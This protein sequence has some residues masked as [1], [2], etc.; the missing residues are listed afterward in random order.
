MTRAHR[1]RRRAWWLLGLCA[2]LAAVAGG[3]VAVLATR[4]AA[5]TTEAQSPLLGKPAPD[6]GGAS[7]SGPPVSLASLRGRFVLVNFFASWCAPCRT[8]APELVTLA[9]QHK[10]TGD[11]AIVGVTFNDSAQAALAFLR[12]TGEEWPAIADP[13]GQIALAYGVR[14][15]PESYLVA[16][17]G[18]VVAKFVGPVTAKGVDRYM[19]LAAREKA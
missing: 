10:A 11:L 9:F 4:P 3:L 2:V 12:S 18:R 14:G 8:E 15:P 16:P 13:N 1:R 19:A 17:D 6:F 7:L 5:T